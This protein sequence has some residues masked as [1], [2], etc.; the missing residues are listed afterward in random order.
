[1]QMLIFD[2]KFELGEMVEELH[3]GKCCCFGGWVGTL[4]VLSKALILSR[5][6]NIVS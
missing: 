5:S 3:L 4:E 6:L 2:E 1:M